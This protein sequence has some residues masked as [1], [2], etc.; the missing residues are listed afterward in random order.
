MSTRFF[1]TALFLYQY[2]SEV[3]TQLLSL[4]HLCPSSCVT[5]IDSCLLFSKHFDR[6][7][8]TSF[9]QFSESVLHR[10]GSTA[11]CLP[12]CLPFTFDP[13]ESGLH[14]YWFGSHTVLFSCFSSSSS[15]SS[16]FLTLQSCCGVR[17]GAR[18]H[19]FLFD[20]ETM[21]VFSFRKQNAATTLAWLVGKS[22]G[23]FM[24]CVLSLGRLFVVLSSD[25]IWRLADQ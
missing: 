13:P 20:I 7:S 14:F 25:L 23:L 4:I 24:I 19:N 3:V 2:F 8:T 16:K 9:F 21:F 1:F 5:F 6:T 18:A 22:V 15:S 10:G 12:A 17:A 11:A